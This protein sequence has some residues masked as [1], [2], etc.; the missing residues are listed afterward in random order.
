[1]LIGETEFPISDI[2]AME[3]VGPSRIVFS[4]EGQNYEIG[5]DSNDSFCGR[6]YLEFYKQSRK[7]Q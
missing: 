7:E 3:I 1:M 4:V 2:S 6:K 5:S